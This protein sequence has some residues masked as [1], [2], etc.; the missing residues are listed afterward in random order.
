MSH[1]FLLRKIL[2]METPG[3]EHGRDAGRAQPGRLPW[4]RRCALPAGGPGGERES[5]PL[6]RGRERGGGG[7]YYLCGRPVAGHGSHEQR[8]APRGFFHRGCC[9]SI[10]LNKNRRY[11][12]TSQSERPGVWHD[13]R[14]TSR[15]GGGLSWP[16]TVTPASS[17]RRRASPWAPTARWTAARPSGGAPASTP[18]GASVGVIMIKTE[19]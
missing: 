9:A 10:C 7:V 1:L 11:I 12:G 3:Q 14:T 6:F 4:R 17:P 15:A 16:A 19:E 5:G 2:R 18:A 13:G 8:K